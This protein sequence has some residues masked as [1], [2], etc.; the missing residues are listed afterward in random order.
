MAVEQEL[1][2]TYKVVQVDGVSKLNSHVVW[3]ENTGEWPEHPEVIHHKDG[4]TQND[5]FDNLLLMTRAENNLYGKKR[6]SRGKRRP[7]SY[8]TVRVNGKRKKYSHY[9]WHQHTEYWPDY[10]NKREVI[11]HLDGNSLNDSFDNLQLMSITEHR[12]LL[13]GENHPSWQSNA[14]VTAKYTRHLKYPNK[15]PPLTE[16]ERRKMNTHRREQY[17]KKH[18][19][20]E[21]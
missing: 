4:N 8:R 14:S 15:Y 13:S 2:S 3:H 18:I 16:E 1:K 19:S 12:S 20:E 17:K 9:I 7:N 6:P 11:H 5:S 21:N 10:A